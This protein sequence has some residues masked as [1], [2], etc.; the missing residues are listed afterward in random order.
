VQEWHALE[1]PDRY[2]ALYRGIRIA[3][4]LKRFLT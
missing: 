1:I 4:L 3:R 2:F